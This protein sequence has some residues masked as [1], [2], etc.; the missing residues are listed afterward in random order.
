MQ[1]TGKGSI[2][3]AAATIDYRMSARVLE[4]PEFA[5]GATEDELEEFTEA[6]IP[7]K[8]T[9]SLADPS[10]KPDIKAMLREEAKEEIKERLLDKLLGGDEEPEEEPTDEQPE[11]KKKTRDK[12]KDALKDL[13]GG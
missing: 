9:G 3:L 10:I 7:L 11:E 2:D 5:Q 12:V 8:I 6:V 13:L 1:L 4:R